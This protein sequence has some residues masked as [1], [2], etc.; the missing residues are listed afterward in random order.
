[1]ILFVCLFVCFLVCFA[2]FRLFFLR[3][4]LVVTKLKKE[5]GDV[6]EG[7]REGGSGVN[8][9]QIL[10]LPA[11]EWW[12]VL[13]C[14]FSRIQFLFVIISRSR[15]PS[16]WLWKETEEAKLCCEW[17]FKDGTVVCA[18]FAKFD[19]GLSEINSIHKPFPS[20]LPGETL[21]CIEW[22]NR[23]IQQGAFVMKKIINSV[24]YEALN[25][26]WVMDWLMMTLSNSEHGWIVWSEEC[27]E[28]SRW[29]IPSSR[30][31]Y[32]LY[33]ELPFFH[34]ISYSSSHYTL[35]LERRSR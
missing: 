21:T 1:M 8:I 30:I 27:K 5:G 15:V 34:F 28:E 24:L 18:G 20:I 13:C 35:F 2:N 6:W 16:E 7:G 14:F 10:L 22:G 3:Y 26:R 25:W 33:L 29:T 12:Q 23:Y 11:Y 31:G 19:R 4:D 9:L 32:G 17:D